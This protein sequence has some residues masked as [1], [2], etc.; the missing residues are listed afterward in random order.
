MSLTGKLMQEMRA[1]R[2]RKTE[3]LASLQICAILNQ[4]RMQRGK[5]Q[6]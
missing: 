5:V 2:R 6:E 1:M 4:T 3:R